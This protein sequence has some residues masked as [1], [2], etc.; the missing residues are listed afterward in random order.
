MKEN[1]LKTLQT[2][3]GNGVFFTSN[4]TDFILPGLVIDGIGE[5][6]F[7]II[8]KQLEKI[9]ISAD[10]APYGKGDQTIVNKEVRNVWEIDASKLS[11]KNPSWRKKTDEIIKK[12]KKD[13]GLEEAKIEAHLYK[14]LIYEEGS[15]F[16]SHKDSEKE[17]GMFGTLIINLPSKHTG[18]ELKVGFDGKEH[19]VDFS[20]LS[21]DYKMAYTAF[22]SD[23]EHEVL[24]VQSGYRICLVY[25]LIQTAASKANPAH[26]YTKQ[27]RELSQL[28]REAEPSF[29]SKLKAVILGHEYTPANFSLETLKHHD[30][31]RAIALMEA[32][33]EAGYYATLGLVTK[34]VMGEAG[35]DDSYQYDY[36]DRNSQ[37]GTSSMGE[38]YEESLY[39]EHWGSSR[40]PDLGNVRLSEEDLISSS[41][42]DEGEPTEEYEEGFTGNAGMTVEYWYHHGAVVIWSI[43]HHLEI[44]NNLHVDV[45][46]SW[47]TYYRDSLQEHKLE[48]VSVIKHLN[49]EDYKEGYRKTDFSIVV[50]VLTELK[51]AT[52]LK[53]QFSLL[54][55][56]FD[57]VSVTTWMSLLCHYDLTVFDHFFEV[58][59]HQS[60]MSYVQHYLELMKEVV[61]VDDEKYQSWV[62]DA[63]AKLPEGL[64]LI[65]MEDKNEK[66]NIPLIV[67][68]LLKLRDSYDDGTTVKIGKYLTSFTERNYVNNALVINLLE[69]DK[70]GHKDYLVK[71]IGDYCLAD[72]QRRT[73]E[74][75]TPPSD[76][77]LKV[78]QGNKYKYV[79][80]MLEDFLSSPTAE[81]FDYKAR[82]D[83]RQDVESAILSAK[84]DL[85]T[86][87]I[88]KGS[89]HILRLIKTQ[90]S[91]DR[92]LKKW[93]ADSSLLN[94]LRDTKG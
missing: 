42:L 41:A 78:P 25:N 49:E 24:P 39:V 33:K 17:K 44:I 76:F 51:D 8:E 12:V 88:I 15:F 93:K 23:C 69:I 77:S 73:V 86:Q 29:S 37:S 19:R 91:Y 2:I 35:Y 47:L 87:T 90:A 74:K 21:T 50:I 13:L 58:I 67:A 7:P 34:Y 4:T 75:P 52:L 31:P 61:Q 65:S 80:E 22:F 36:Y 68:S 57:R 71:M 38:I 53:D 66:Q 79:W 55:K 20:M 54:V 84:I 85:R 40:F 30:K 64:A 56:L 62:K 10:Q 32:A 5:V 70:D 16:L 48:A 82:K 92:Q 83:L 94:N 43:N 27:T 89:P 28:L 45:K 60:R 59:L 3:E 72:L 14:L 18:G 46:L 9:I 6:G 1:L 63:F 26:S 81:V 11:L